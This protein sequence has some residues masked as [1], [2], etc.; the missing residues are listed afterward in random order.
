MEAN[1]RKTKQ[2]NNSARSGNGP[3]SSA[4][5]SSQGGN[6]LLRARALEAAREENRELRGQ[7][8]ELKASN[9]RLTEGRINLEQQHRS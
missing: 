6:E 5:S 9:E 1:L 7:V 8:D 3:L 4:V 2:G